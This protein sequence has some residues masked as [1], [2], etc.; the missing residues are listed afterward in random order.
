MTGQHT[1]RKGPMVQWLYLGGTVLAFSLAWWCVRSPVRAGDAGFFGSA[2]GTDQKQPG[3][4]AT[5]VA[6]VEA[7]GRMGTREAQA[8]LLALLP[9]LPADDEARQEIVPL[10]RPSGLDDEFAGRLAGQ[11]DGPTLTATEKKQL[12]F[13]LALV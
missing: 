5:R 12:A 13:T 10:L 7:L 4:P 11:L 1:P 8:E 3:A 6:A 9:S 2:G